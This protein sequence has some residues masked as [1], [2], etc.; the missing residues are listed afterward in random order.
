VLVENNVPKCW[1]CVCCIAF[2]KYI[3]TVDMGKN[4]ATK[5]PRRKVR[6][7]ENKPSTNADLEQILT[8]AAQMLAEKKWRPSLG[9]RPKPSLQDPQP[10]LD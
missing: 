9:A 2:S 6:S 5:N 3:N 4:K 8:D 10:V 1:P 7:R